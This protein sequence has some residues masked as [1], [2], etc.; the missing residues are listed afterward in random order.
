M[1]E[2]KPPRYFVQALAKGLKVLESFD[3]T[4][5]VMSLT[6]IARALDLN[7]PTAKRFLQTLCDLGYVQQTSDK[8]YRLGTHSL[9]L[10]Y[11]YLAS[12]DLANVAQPFMQEAVHRTGETVN[13][14]VRDGREVVY[15]SRI[16]AAPR[17]LTVNLQVG[18]RLPLHATALG[19]A[20]LFDIPTSRLE[21][22]LG[23]APWTRYTDATLC[24]PVSLGR[25]LDTARERGFTV[26]DGDLELG[27][28]SVGAPVRNVS[29][30]IVA[31]MNVSTSTA[32][33]SKR[34]VLGAFST[35]LL[36][37]ASGLSR[38]LSHRD[39]AAS[40]IARS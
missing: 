17:I 10:G 14:A 8:R 31:A 26:T 15:V 34:K 38:A 1:V 5:P 33:V 4:R 7:K 25:D 2:D 32:R 36:E 11:R 16:A 20:L 12:L 18:S 30:Q 9:D 3:T 39:V 22:A 37:A 28:R 6:D 19:K 24:D 13:L 23:P 35:V 21:E 29:G 40:A 27:L